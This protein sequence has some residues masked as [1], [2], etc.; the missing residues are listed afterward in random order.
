MHPS[1]LPPSSSPGSARLARGRRGPGLLTAVVLTASVA[2]SGCSTSSDQ[3]VPA[4]SP[5]PS[6]SAGASTSQ[7]VHFTVGYA[8]DV[9]MHMPVMES[10]PAG[11]GDITANIAAETPGS[12]AWIW[13][14]AGW[15]CLSLRTGSTRATPPSAPLP[16]SWPPWRDPAGTAARPPPTTL[17]IG[18]R[19]A[20]WPPWT[21]WTLTGWATRAPTGASRTPRCPSR[22]TSWSGA[23]AP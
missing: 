22:S 11:S 12:R 21:P 18:G 4:R 6:A 13:P 2:V 15:R 3:A 20:S 8:G 9:L 19:P 7:D 14:C 17:R 10:T 5:S 23:G 1:T 16:R